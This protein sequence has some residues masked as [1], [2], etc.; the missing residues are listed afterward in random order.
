VTY[1]NH[2]PEAKLDCVTGEHGARR[3]GSWEYYDRRAV[4]GTRTIG[5]ALAYWKGLGVEA[6]AADIE[7]EAAQVRRLLRSMPPSLF[8]EVGAGPGTF[9]ADLP[10]WGIALDQSENA[11]R[12]L[13]SG[14]ADTPVVRGDA[15]RLPVRDRAV[16]RVFATHIY[17]LLTQEQRVPFL[18]EARRV[19]QEVVLLDAGRPRGVPAEHWQHRTL[20]G[21]ESF[22]VFRRHFDTEGL[23]AEIDGR[24]VFSGRFYVIVSA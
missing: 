14:H 8:V 16:A 3:P 6:T 2:L 5:H 7:A 21:R 4:D 17:G 9:T 12:V 19:A 22:K 20:G 15:L 11:L 18:S 10:G 24:P 1:R 23:A 13:R